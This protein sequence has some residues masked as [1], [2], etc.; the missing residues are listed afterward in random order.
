MLS[1]VYYFVDGCLLLLM[2]VSV[3]GCCI[4]L[5]DDRLLLLLMIN[6]VVDGCLLLLMAV[7]VH[8]LLLLIVCSCSLV[9]VITHVCC[10]L[11][12]DFG[13]LA[14][15]NVGCLLVLLLSLLICC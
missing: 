15:Y 10:R 4:C 7:T 14:S 8:W 1:V 6:V 11:L 13:L 9:T 12:A 5:V 3:D 2:A